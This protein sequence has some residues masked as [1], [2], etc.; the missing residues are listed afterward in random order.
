[1]MLLPTT[2]PDAYPFQVDAI[3]QLREG[4]RDGYLRQ[5]LSSPTGSGKTVIM[6][7]IIAGTLKKDGALF[8]VDRLTLLEQTSRRFSEY[9]IPH[10]LMSGDP[11]MDYGHHEPVIIGMVQTLAKRGIPK[12]GVVLVDEAHIRYQYLIDELPKLNMPLI[13]AT[14]TPIPAWLGN[15]Y[16]R[17]V[18]VTTTNKLIEDK[19]LSPYIMRAGAEIDMTGAPISST[20]EWLPSD[21]RERGRTIIG[22]IVSTWVTETNRH[23]GGPVKTMLFSADIAHGRELCEEFQQAGIDARQ[24][25]AYDKPETVNDTMARFRA[26]EFPII[27]SCDMLVRGVDVPDV[28]CLA[29]ARPLRKSFAAH[30]QMLGRALRI[31]HG[32]D[33]ALIVDFTGNCIGFLHETADFFEHGVSDLKAGKFRKV[34]RTEKEKI[35]V[36]CRSCETIL[37][38]GADLCPV[39]GTERRRRRS[40]VERLPGKM[41][42]IDP[43]QKGRTWQGS[44]A[45]LWKAC[46]A[47]ANRALFRHGDKDRALRMARGSY[48][49]LAGSWPPRDWRLISDAHYV[50][51]TIE[52]KMAANYRAW[53]KRQ[54]S[55]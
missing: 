18:N 8:G 15:L 5:I 4:I 6:G 9:G 12:R 47:Y 37:P 38:P 33:K 7:H 2:L 11:R 29:I 40:A 30:I 34:T 51:K 20:G 3:R 53:K 31:A 25:S 16:Q 23:F 10:G 35:E 26:G 24:V 44:E 54:K 41:I 32:K 43:V 50:P 48:Y 21:I 1:M 49:D 39:C 55:A 22:D 14:A 52:R 46:S 28:K 27:V 42:T 45:A 17:V 13:G 36:K 19:F